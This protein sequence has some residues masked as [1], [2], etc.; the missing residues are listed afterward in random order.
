MAINSTYYLNAADLAT[1]TA[2]YLDLSLTLIAPDGFYSDGTISREQSLGILLAAAPCSTCGTACGGSIGG[3]GGTGV[4]LINLD[5]GSTPS[6]VGAIVVK[7][8]PASVPDGIRVIYDGDTYN[9][10]S[11]PIDGLHKS[12]NPTGFTVIGDVSYDCNLEGNIT[13]LPTIAEYLYNGTSFVATGNTQS[14]TINPGDV[15]LSPVAPGE[16]VMVI[17]KVNPTPN[18]L[19]FEMLGPCSG[20]AWNINIGCP[21]LL[22]SFQSSTVQPS[23]NVACDT[24]LTETFY[25]AKVHIA[26]DTYVGQ[27]DYVFQDAYGAMPLPDG[28]YLTD[29]V[30]SP[31]KVIEVQNGIIV[32]L[33]GCQAGPYSFSMLNFGTDTDL[34][35]C[36][37]WVTGDPP[38]SRVDRYSTGFTLN[39]GDI[40][41]TDNTLTTPFTFPIIQYYGYAQ[42]IPSGGIFRKWCKVDTDGTVLEVDYCS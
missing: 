24:P 1:A 30:A 22:P 36:A 17:P 32:T 38:Y 19:N 39:V 4:Y 15:S 13:N 7:F 33:I 3:S 41:Y 34:E 9:T 28:F 6:D 20:T 27:Y 12:T 42:P 16:C 5:A 2:V 40:L 37:D 23:L 25:F 18:I 8:N 35:S 26:S 11:S 14:I 31:N 10:L 21:A 29:N